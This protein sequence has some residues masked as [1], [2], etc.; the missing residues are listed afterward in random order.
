MVELSNVYAGPSNEEMVAFAEG[1]FAAADGK[2]LT[3]NP[4]HP[5]NEELLQI[6]WASGWIAYFAEQDSDEE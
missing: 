1:A 5:Q 4:F 2:I 6:A 3:D